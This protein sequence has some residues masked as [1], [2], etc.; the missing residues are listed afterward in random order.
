MSQRL[1]N[2]GHINVCILDWHSDTNG[3]LA[4]T[5]LQT[6][7]NIP[8]VQFFLDS[9][10]SLDSYKESALHIMLPHDQSISYRIV[11]NDALNAEGLLAVSL[12]TVGVFYSKKANFIIFLQ[13][14]RERYPVYQARKK[15]RGVFLESQT[16]E[17]TK[18]GKKRSDWRDVELEGSEE[19]Q[20]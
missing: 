9:L 10:Q 14:C 4:S 2:A 1:S 5:L 13:H 8:M 7:D 15:R 12:S 17:R 16:R 20:W 11:S 6:P 19:L 3:G 18:H